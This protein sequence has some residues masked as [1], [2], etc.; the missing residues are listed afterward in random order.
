[1]PQGPM[2]PMSRMPGPSG[3]PPRFPGVNPFMPPDMPPMMGMNTPPP[4]GRVLFVIR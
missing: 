2:S 3:M 4:M 1:M